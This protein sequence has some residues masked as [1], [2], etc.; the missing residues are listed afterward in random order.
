MFASQHRSLQP[1]APGQTLPGA[2]RGFSLSARLDEHLD[3]IRQDYEIMA[4]ELTDKSNQSIAFSGL[5]A[6][7]RIG[8]IVGHP[9]GGWLVHPERRWALFQAPFWYQ[10]PFALPCFVAAAIGTVSVILGCFTLQEV[11]SIFSS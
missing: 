3:L 11:T 6:S 8:Q 1:S 7:Y 2:P 4:T 10:Y 5:G 9:L